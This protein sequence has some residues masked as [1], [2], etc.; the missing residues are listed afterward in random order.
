MR[1]SE[2]KSAA[3]TAGT[4]KAKKF[5]R[6]ARFAIIA[7][8]AFVVLIAL[9]SIVTEWQQ[10]KKSL[11]AKRG[12]LAGTGDTSTTR[13]APGELRVP[14]RSNSDPVTP[15]PGRAVSF[16]GDGFTTYCV[17]SDGRPN[18][19]VGDPV[20]PCGNGPMSY[21]YVRNNTDKEIVVTYAFQ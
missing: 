6:T 3:E 17:Y 19:M 21:A 20:N 8:V 2:A 18:G 13:G 12:Q 16:T 7:L 1:F 11:S 9:T 15:P 10:E 14:A 4:E 5:R